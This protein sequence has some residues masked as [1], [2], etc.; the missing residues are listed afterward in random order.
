LLWAYLVGGSGSGKSTICDALAADNIHTKR[1]SQF[2]GL[3][4]GHKTED[5]SDVSLVS[6]LFDKGMIVPDFTSILGL[7]PMM[8]EKIYAELRAIY[9][10]SAQVHYGNAIERDYRSMNDQEIRSRRTVHEDRYDPTH[11]QPFDRNAGYR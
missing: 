2:T 1:V 5:G 7:S 3:H 8:Q 9:D 10:G 4:S 6:K 11:D